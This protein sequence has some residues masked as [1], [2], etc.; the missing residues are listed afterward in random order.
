VLDAE[1]TGCCR[2]HG[3]EEAKGTPPACMA[4]TGALLWPPTCMAGTGALLWPPTCKRMAAA[5]LGTLEAWLHTGVI[6]SWVV[7]ATLPTLLLLM[8]CPPVTTAWRCA[9]AELSL[10]TVP[11]L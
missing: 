3:S 1:A 9:G 4:G 7:L 8:K 2:D 11:A 5:L 6:T 10:E